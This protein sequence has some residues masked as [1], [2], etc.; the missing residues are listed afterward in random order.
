MEDSERRKKF[1]AAAES[2]KTI[3]TEIDV[4]GNNSAI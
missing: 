1:A 3:S 4:E 2:A